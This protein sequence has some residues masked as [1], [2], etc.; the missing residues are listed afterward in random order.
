M[1]TPLENRNIFLRVMAMVPLG[2]LPLWGREGVTL[3]I[4]LLKKTK[5]KKSDLRKEPEK[6]PI[7]KESKTHRSSRHEE[8]Q[9]IRKTSRV[10]YSDEVVLKVFLIHC[11]M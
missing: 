7:D 11:R 8:N 3:T 10:S 6:I 5:R 4:S 2:C 1:R 9:K